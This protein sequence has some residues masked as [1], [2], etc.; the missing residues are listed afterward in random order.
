VWSKL[1]KQP[2]KVDRDNESKLNNPKAKERHN[3]LF[4]QFGVN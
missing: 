4:A 1:I 2:N 3:S